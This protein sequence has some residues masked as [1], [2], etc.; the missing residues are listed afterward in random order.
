MQRTATAGTGLGVEVEM[1]V[2][3]LQMI[4]KARTIWS[5][6]DDRLLRAGVRKALFRP[7]DVG[8]E[9]FQAEL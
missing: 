3:A 8:V 4:G 6:P 5:D 9:V 7:G 2:L 1:D